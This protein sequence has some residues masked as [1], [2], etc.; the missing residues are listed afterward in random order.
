MLKKT[1]F[2]K[3]WNIKIENNEKQDRS[4]MCGKSLLLLLSF[5]AYNIKIVWNFADVEEKFLSGNNQEENESIYE[6][7]ERKEMNN[8]DR[9]Q[10]LCIFK[11]G[12]AYLLTLQNY[13]PRHYNEQ[14]W[15]WES[16]HNKI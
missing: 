15:S 10:L 7:M 14:F 5:A 16:S 12:Q 6:K 8:N 13:I 3:A 9:S 1:L 11:S 2:W 4:R